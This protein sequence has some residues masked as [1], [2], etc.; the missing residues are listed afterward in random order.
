LSIYNSESIYLSSIWFSK[1]TVVNLRTKGPK[2]ISAPELT[3]FQKE[4]IFGSMLGDLHA[5]LTHL[6]GKTRLRFYMSLINQDLIYHL[7]SIFKPYVK[8]EPKTYQ[9]KLNQLTKKLHID[10]GFSNLKYPEFNWVSEDFYVK[11][12]NKK[13]KIIPR[14]SFNRITAVSLAF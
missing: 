13:F 8:T 14:D 1:E 3:N 7:Y 9:R 11:L 4:V 12:D 2:T 5:E 10:I 6:N